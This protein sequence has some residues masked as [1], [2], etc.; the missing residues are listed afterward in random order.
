MLNDV[1]EGRR[2]LAAS[3]DSLPCLELFQ[4]YG[5]DEFKSSALMS[6]FSGVLMGLLGA[7]SMLTMLIV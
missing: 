5:W 1:V 7:A 2:L 4:E 3:K 6:H